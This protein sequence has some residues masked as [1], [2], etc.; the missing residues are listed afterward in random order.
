[1]SWLIGFRMRQRFWWNQLGAK[2]NEA[3][4]YQV[5]GLTI[6]EA[7]DQYRR[8][9]FLSICAKRWSSMPLARTEENPSVFREVLF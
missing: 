1:M 3:V 2:N 8:G 4:Y 6:F 7:F 5:L 9:N